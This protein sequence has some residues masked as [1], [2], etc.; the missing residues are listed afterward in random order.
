MEY[1]RKA[2]QNSYRFWNP[3]YTGKVEKAKALDELD[4]VGMI[5]RRNSIMDGMGCNYAH[6]LAKDPALFDNWILQLKAMVKE[7]RNHPSILIWSM[8]NE[9]TLINARNCG[10]LDAVEP[11]IK[12][13]AKALLE[14]DPTR[15]VMIDGGNA[16]KDQS[17]PVSGAHYVETSI[18]AP[19]R[20]VFHRSAPIDKFFPA[21]W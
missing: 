3:L 10:I 8:E 21:R 4:A 20:A 2:N 13:A 11:H 6:A 1:C 7:E 9:L 19:I 15:P 5:V 18:T 16:L 14:L 17:L 12:R